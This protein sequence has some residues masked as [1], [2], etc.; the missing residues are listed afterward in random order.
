MLQHQRERI[1]AADRH[2]LLR[3]TGPNVSRCLVPKID[4]V[5][6]DQAHGKDRGRRKEQ[7]V[8]TD[9]PDQ[10]ARDPRPE[11]R[12]ARRAERDDGKQPLACI[13]GVDVV[14]V[15]PELGDH[16][17]AEDADPEEENQPDRRFRL[18]EQIE[19]RQA[20]DEKGGDDVDK[21]PARKA[22]R[23]CA[24]KWHQHDQQ[25]GLRSIGVT[26]ELRAAWLIEDQRLPHRLH[27]VVGGEYQEDVE[28]EQQKLRPLAVP[29]IGE[30]AQEPLER[31]ARGR[32]GGRNCGHGRGLGCTERQTSAWRR[33][34]GTC[35][36][37]KPVVPLEL[38]VTR[39]GPPGTSSR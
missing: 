10:V 9:R 35:P 18:G 23:Q 8:D 33:G 24:V 17:E 21:P 19:R 2:V 20:G 4:D 32:R 30:E 38:A 39:S 1:A 26:L 11:H 25:N 37:R 15:R 3:G 36:S 13:G 7:G 5:E 12:A 31:P 27:H 22:C 14:R 34:H 29:H 28:R 6:Q 16:H